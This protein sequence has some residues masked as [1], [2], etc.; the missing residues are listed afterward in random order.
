MTLLLAPIFLPKPTRCPTPDRRRPAGR[1][2]RGRRV[3]FQ[4]PQPQAQ[5]PGQGP[6]LGK[7]LPPDS[8]RLRYSVFL[9]GDVGSPIPAERGGEPSLNFMRQQMLQAGRNSATVFLGDN[10]YNQGMPPVGAY[11]R[12]TA[13]GRLNEQLNILKGYQG[14]KYI[15]PGNHDW[16]QGYKVGWRR[17]IREQVYAEHYLAQGLGGILLHR[18]LHGAPQRLPRALRNPAARRPGDDCPE[19]AVVSDRAAKP[20]LRRRLRGRYRG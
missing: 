1:A 16:I 18:R 20:A 7:N 2:G 4:S 9:I 17:C 11:D 6:G 15:T 10:I 5:L 12:K 8:S 13:E 19:F 14:E 3:R